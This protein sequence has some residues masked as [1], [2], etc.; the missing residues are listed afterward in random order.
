MPQHPETGRKAIKPSTNEDPSKAEQ[1]LAGPKRFSRV[2]VVAE[3]DNDG[4]LRIG[5]RATS[6]LS[7]APKG[8]PLSQG[9]SYVFENVDLSWIYVAGSNDGDAITYN[10]TP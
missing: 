2:D 5:Y 8:F 6:V 7:G 1:V 3:S 10:A 4:V 9:D